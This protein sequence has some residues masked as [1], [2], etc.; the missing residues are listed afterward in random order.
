MTITPPTPTS[1]DIF[2]QQ[3]FSTTTTGSV[4]IA[5]LEAKVTEQQEI[6]SYHE[7]R[8][9]EYK[10]KE[11]AMKNSYASFVRD[12]E[13]KNKALALA[14]IS[15]Q[16]LK[17]DFIREKATMQ[18]KID[19]LL[20]ERKAYT[21]RYENLSGQVFFELQPHQIGIIEQI[22]DRYKHVRICLDMDKQEVKYVLGA[23]DNEDILPWERS[24]DKLIGG[25]VCSKCSTGTS[26]L[27]HYHY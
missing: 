20:N 15:N 2:Q 23:N 25:S 24:Y 8:E 6:I 9:L 26:D 14:E 1:D 17:T 12:L 19:L 22:K 27:F 5:E 21:E 16:E 18:G 11:Q 10:E 3:L 4:R 7:Q 13:A